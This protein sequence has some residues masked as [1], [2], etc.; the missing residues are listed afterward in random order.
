[1][2]YR[3]LLCLSLLVVGAHGLA[4]A[5][6]RHACGT[7]QVP[8]V[9]GLTKPAQPSQTSGPFAVG[10]TL[11]VRA[12]SFQLVGGGPYYTTTT[13]RLVGDN[14]Y[15]FVEDE[16]WSTP[17]VTDPGIQ[18]LAA[19]FD[20][21]TPAA[22]DRGIYAI[23]R[24]LF[25]APPDADGDPRILIVVLDILDSPFTGITYVGY[26]DTQNQAPPI[27]KEILYVDSGALGSDSTLARATLAHEFQHMLH[28]AADP[29]EEKWVDEGCSE[30]AELAC[31]YKDTSQT[32]GEAYLQVPNISLTAWSDNAF[33]FDQSF[34]WMTYFVQRY[35]DATLNRLVSLPENGV[36]AV[37]L[38]MADAGSGD[39]FQDHFARWMAATYL[40]GPGD[41][42]YA[43]IDLGPVYRDT[44]GVPSD[45]R[46]RVV[47]LWGIDYLDLGH[48]AG[49]GIDI[50][51]SGDNDLMV[52]LI[53][54]V[55]GASSVDRVRIPA[56]T[57]R[58]IGAF[59]SA[60]RA[61][62]V[63]RSSGADESYTL[64]SLLME[65]NSALACDFDASG[66]VDF[67]DFLTFA[68]HYARSSGDAGFDPSFDLDAD[69][70]IDFADFL[71]FARHFGTFV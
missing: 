54:T 62:A 44:L 4:D 52:L 53:S 10:D 18:G 71:I 35:G 28:W 3:I 29:D 15:V 42:G 55:E 59:G 31:G 13:C 7:H 25:G 58:R 46:S 26:F 9:P 5:R 19:A 16:V 12:Y 8:R 70:D 64:G 60:T 61:L 51:S 37:E 2:T 14:C 69:R 63:T 68:A 22:P 17:D 38:A 50:G 57:R 6:P 45:T 39:T 21:A 33:D 43:R 1:M 56:G 66:L 36:Q 47:R 48:T 23:D 41:Q 11:T 65:G 40:D 32:A 30:Y 24:D 27:Q 20:R 49:V 67:T 34:L